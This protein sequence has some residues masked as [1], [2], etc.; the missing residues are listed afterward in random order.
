M[1]IIET[2]FG[3]FYLLQLYGSKSLCCSTFGGALKNLKVLKIIN[4][5]SV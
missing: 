2:K 3:V 4:F 1:F 5:L